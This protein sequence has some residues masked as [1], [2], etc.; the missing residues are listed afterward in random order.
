MRSQIRAAKLRREQAKLQTQAI[1]RQV[2]AQT[3]AA[4]FSFLSSQQA[5]TASERQ[6]EAAEVAF[7]G[8]RDEL[9]VGTRTTQDLL[10]AE[11]DLLNA[12]LSLVSAERDTYVAAARLLQIMGRLTPEAVSIAGRG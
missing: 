6:V 9:S 1:E 8:A 12:R 7:A 4:W 3:A 11:Q 5:V 10:D 2:R